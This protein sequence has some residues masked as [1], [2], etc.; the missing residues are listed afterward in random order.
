MRALDLGLAV[1]IF[2]RLSPPRV[3]REDKIMISYWPDPKPTG[4][5][6]STLLRTLIGAV[7]GLFLIAILALPLAIKILS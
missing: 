5:A 4:Q 2:R 6:Q 1:N 3:L 7:V